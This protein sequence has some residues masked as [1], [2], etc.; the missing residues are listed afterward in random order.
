M[1]YKIS[2]NEFLEF[3]NNYLKDSD[4]LKT[5]GNAFCDTFKIDNECIRKTTSVTAAR[6]IIDSL[7]EWTN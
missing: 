7:V 4:P 1:N 2:Y 5:F 6:I 3:K